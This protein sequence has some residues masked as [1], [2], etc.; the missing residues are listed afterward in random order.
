VLRGIRIVPAFS[1][2]L[3][4]LT[5][6]MFIAYHQTISEASNTGPSTHERRFPPVVSTTHD[7]QAPIPHAMRFS[8]LTS[9]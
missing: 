8:M 9:V 3:N 6:R 7:K 1:K 5:H 2:Q 4:L